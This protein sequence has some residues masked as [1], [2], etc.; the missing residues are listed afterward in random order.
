MSK[1]RDMNSRVGGGRPDSAAAGK[2]TQAAVD[3]QARVIEAK[4]ER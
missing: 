4:L 2:V 1:R 3:K